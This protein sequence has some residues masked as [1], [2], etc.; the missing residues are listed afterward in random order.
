MTSAVSWHGEVELTVG[1]GVLVRPA[2]VGF[3]VFESM[4]ALLAVIVHCGDRER[5]VVD[6]ASAYL[7]LVRDFTCITY[8]ALCDSPV[9]RLEALQVLV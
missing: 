4:I 9:V 2:G 3:E 1:H 8:R 5:K 6:V 7:K